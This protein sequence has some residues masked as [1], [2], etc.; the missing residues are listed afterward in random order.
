MDAWKNARAIELATFQL[1]GIKEHLKLLEDR[2]MN[3]NGRLN[4]LE[5]PSKKETKKTASKKK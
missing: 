5:K 4:E 3:L 2:I 1:E